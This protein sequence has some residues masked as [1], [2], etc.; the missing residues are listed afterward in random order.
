MTDGIKY[1][2]A[3]Q[4][5]AEVLKS[6]LVVLDFYS[7]ECPPCEALASKFESLSEI[8]GDHI[9]FLKIFRQENRELAETLGVKSSPTLIFYKDGEIVGDR[10][11]GRIKR[12]DIVKNLDALLTAETAKKLRAKIVPIETQCD[13][14]ILGG[15]PGGLTAGIYAG[16]AKLDTIIVD[17]GGPGGQVTTTHLVSNYPGFPKPVEG[18]MLTHYFSEQ[19]AEAG[20]KTRYSVDVSNIDLHKKQILVDGFETIKAK[21]IIVATGSSYK[22]LGVP[23]EKEYKGRGISYCATCDAKYYEGKEVIVVGGG[24]S[25]IEEALFITKFANKVTVVHQFAELQANKVAQE[26]AFANEKIEF[27]LLHEPRKFEKTETGMRVNVENMATGECSSLTTDG[28]FIFAGMQANVG[29]FENQFQLDQYGYI[30]VDAFMHTSITDIFAVGDVAEKMYRQIT[31]AASEGTI[32][33]IT[34]AKE[35]DE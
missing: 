30:K 9:T 11:I 15:G 23:G 17:T 24:N 10:L 28:I 35:L 21:K 8:Y 19:A 13:L 14:L 4:Y 2:K 12:A 25:A 16:Q 22:P 6:G 3:E 5:E 31:V 27:L 33:A 29:D 34:A 26:R 18:F 20:V 32:A 7:S 1:I